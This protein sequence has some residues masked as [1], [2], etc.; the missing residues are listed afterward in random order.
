[1]TKY[2]LTTYSVSSKGFSGSS[3]GKESA[4]NAGDLGSIP[5]LGRSSGEEATH[6]GY[7]A[8]RTP[9]SL[10][11]YSLWGHKESDTSER[12][13]ASTSAWH[14]FNCS[15]NSNQHV[16]LTSDLSVLLVQWGQGKAMKKQCEIFEW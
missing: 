2:F 4:F 5:G 13:S 12:L 16:D 14:C 10:A 9:W 7:S 1:M 3:N 15:E 6:S 11:G 8:W